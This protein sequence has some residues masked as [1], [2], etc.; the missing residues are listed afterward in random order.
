MWK[1]LIASVKITTIIVP[2]II[3][4]E[5]HWP[6]GLA[7]FAT[8]VR[9]ASLI[10]FLRCSWTSAAIYC[11]RYWVRFYYFNFW[12]KIKSRFSFYLAWILAAFSSGGKYWIHFGILAFSC[13]GERHFHSLSTSDCGHCTSSLGNFFIIPAKK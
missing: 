11:S 9:G 10:E 8:N 2:L 12:F 4:R 3:L 6:F 1:F 13:I 7:S 5:V